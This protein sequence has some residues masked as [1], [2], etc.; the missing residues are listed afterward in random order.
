MYFRDLDPVRAGD[1][2]GP[3][4]ILRLPYRTGTRDPRRAVVHPVARRM[5][6]KGLARVLGCR[7]WTRGE[8]EVLGVELTLSMP[9]PGRAALA[10]AAD[11]LAEAP[12]GSSIRMESGGDPIVFGSTIGVALDV[13][14]ADPAGERLAQ[15]T[16][17]ALGASGHIGGWRASG[18]RATLHVYGADPDA[19][20]RGSA[21]VLGPDVPARLLG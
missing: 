16:S 14:C 1:A 7:V 9:R 3:L 13:E 17:Q 8:G 20:V 18:G 19:I 21:S 5:A 12:A 2:R 10:A 15:R 11:A 6:E 4:A